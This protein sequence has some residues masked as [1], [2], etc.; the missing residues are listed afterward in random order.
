MAREILAYLE[1][2]EGKVSLTE[3]LTLDYS[4]LVEMIKLKNEAIEAKNKK[5]LQQQ[6]ENERTMNMKKIKK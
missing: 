6:Q 2:F 5:N 4:L 3:I 1:L